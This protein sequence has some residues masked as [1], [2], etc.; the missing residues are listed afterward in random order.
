MLPRP[1]YTAICWG[2]NSTVHFCATHITPIIPEV[3]TKG[4]G[5]LEDNSGNKIPHPAPD[6]SFV[7]GVVYFQGRIYLLNC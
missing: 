4:S 1:I 3:T 6:F 7:V 2:Y 5:T